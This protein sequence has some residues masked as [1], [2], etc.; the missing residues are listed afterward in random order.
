[1]APVLEYRSISTNYRYKN[2]KFIVFGPSVISS[3]TRT[4]TKS[5]SGRVPIVRDTFS[6]TLVH[7]LV[8]ERHVPGTAVDLP[9]NICTKYPEV[10]RY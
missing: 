10:L 3:K 2:V 9:G 8:H 7:A 4:R 6:N 1:M 5:G